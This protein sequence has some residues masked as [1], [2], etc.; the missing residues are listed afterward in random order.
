MNV[1]HSGQFNEYRL[2]QVAAKLQTGPFWVC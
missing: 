1:V 2:V